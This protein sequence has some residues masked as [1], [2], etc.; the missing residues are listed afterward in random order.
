MPEGS[1]L[2]SLISLVPRQVMLDKN[3]AAA[4]AERSH[5]KNKKREKAAVAVM[6][7][8]EEKS[9]R[10]KRRPSNLPDAVENV[11]GSEVALSIHRICGNELCRNGKS[12]EYLLRTIAAFLETNGFVKTL[13]VFRSEAELEVD[14]RGSFFVNLEKLFDMFIDSS[15]GDPFAVID[16]WKGQDG[17]GLLTDVADDSNVESKGKKKKRKQISDGALEAIE[18]NGNAKSR[19]KVKKKKGN[20]VEDEKKGE[21]DLGFEEVV[22]EKVDELKVLIS[23]PNP[24]TEDAKRKKTDKKKKK[25]E[26]NHVE[27]VDLQALQEVAASSNHQDCP[28]PVDHVFGY[29]AKVKKKDKGKKFDVSTSDE[30]SKEQG[31]NV[32]H[33][34]HNF[35]LEKVGVAI[36]EENT[37]IVEETNKKRKRTSK[38]TTVEAEDKSVANKS[39][40]AKANGV[41][42]K[43]KARKD[44]GKSNIPSNELSSDDLDKNEGDRSLHDPQKELCGD[45]LA[46]GKS[47]KHHT[48]PQAMKKEQQSGEPK[49][50]NAFQRVKID[51]VHFADERLQD[52]SYWALDDSGTGYGAKAQ[53]VLGQVRGRNFRHEKTKKKRGTYRGGQIDLQSHSIKF[54]YSD[55]EE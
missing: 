4:A 37:G 23:N 55:D 50:V 39:K 53:E 10:N 21:E 49:W 11:D 41:D 24:E 38:E 31:K 54:N 45:Q 5:S 47:K 48:G 2:R 17:R 20:V 9:S 42:R 46:N 29:G 18:N 6:E 32:D 7:V 52:N 15:K 36:S 14:D 25:N 44:N 12:R 1:I 27:L 43:G 40:K 22:K 28:N 19:N 35:D 3:A 33:G 30:R 16:C 51:E 13:A 34:F 26:A 8:E